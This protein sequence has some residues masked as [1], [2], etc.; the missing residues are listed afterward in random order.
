MQNR[1]TRSKIKNSYPHTLPSNNGSYQ[2]KFAEVGVQELNY[3]VNI[4]TIAANQKYLV[5]GVSDNDDKPQMIIVDP[6]NRVLKEKNLGKIYKLGSKAVYYTQQELN[7]PLFT[8][9]LELLKKELEQ[10][11]EYLKVKINEFNAYKAH[12]STNEI[13]IIDKKDTQSYKKS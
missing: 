1:V 2:L 4:I 13:G 5:I 6:K 7:S 11:K 9:K 8:P 10:Y 12:L 3:S